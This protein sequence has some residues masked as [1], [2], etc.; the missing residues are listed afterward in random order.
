MTFRSFGVTFDVNFRVTYLHF[1]TRR[2]AGMPPQ[3]IGCS[4]IFILRAGKNLEER[5][6]NYCAGNIQRG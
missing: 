3:K 4:K 5:V 2:F 6:K 1:S